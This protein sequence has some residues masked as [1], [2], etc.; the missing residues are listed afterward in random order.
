MTDPTSLPNFMPSTPGNTPN[1]A[2]ASDNPVRDRVVGVL[3]GLGI[4]ASIDGDGDIEFA[5]VDNEGTSTTLFARV[6]E[7]DLAVVRFFGQWQLAEPVSPDRNER[8]ARCNDLTMQLNIV[9]LSL[10]Q[11]SLVVSAEHVITPNADLDILVPLSVNHILQSVGF[12]FQS[13]LPQDAVAP[14]EA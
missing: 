3:K 12:F 5:I 10:V 14:G 9:K 7:G 8:L 2:P 1:G 4:E 11:E 13:W 6:A